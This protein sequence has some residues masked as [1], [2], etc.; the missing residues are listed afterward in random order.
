MMGSRLGRPSSSLTD[1]G[2]QFGAEL[3]IRT[4]GAKPAVGGWGGSDPERKK[5]A[6]RQGRVLV[7]CP[8]TPAHTASV[9]QQFFCNQR[10]VT[11]LIGGHEVEGEGFLKQHLTCRKFSLNMSYDYFP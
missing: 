2:P 11:I 7:G 6:Q 4:R 5:G 9:A 10:L 8:L 1:K 3:G